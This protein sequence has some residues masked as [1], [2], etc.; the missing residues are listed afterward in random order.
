MLALAFVAL[1]LLGTVAGG[2]ACFVFLPLLPAIGAVVVGVALLPWLAVT[3]YGLV[4]R[5]Q[6]L[7]P[8]DAAEQGQDA[9]RLGG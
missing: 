1:V 3:L 8:F 2:I 5:A 9:A 4:R 6:P 7:R